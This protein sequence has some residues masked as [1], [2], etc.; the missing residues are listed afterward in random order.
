[1]QGAQSRSERDRW[2]FYEAIKLKPN[3]QGRDM[4][5]R[6]A[7]DKSYKKYLA[8]LKKDPGGFYIFAEPLDESGGH[9]A[10]FVD[11]ECAF[12]ADH[13]S[14]LHPHSILDVGSYRH[15]ILGLLA[16]LPVTTI[17]VRSRQPICA[18]ETILTGD[19]KK[20]NLPDSSFD[21]VLSLCALEHFGLGRYG[22]EFDFYADQKAFAEMIR[23]LKPGGRLIFTTTIHRAEPSIAFNAHRIY[24][25]ETI[26]RFCSALTCVDEKFYNHQNRGFC[27]LEEITSDLKWWDVY[28]GCWEK[29]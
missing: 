29:K 6:K 5:P 27:S 10:N 13:L 8:Q 2:T 20:I 26:Q 25:Y 28:C 11:Y 7:M 24:T 4:T 12:A 15:F 9:P 17:D 23:L 19:A 1:M 14:Q 3:D 22:D 18:K 16:H 21:V